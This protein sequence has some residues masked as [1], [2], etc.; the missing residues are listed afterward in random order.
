MRDGAILDDLRAT[1]PDSV[2][3]AIGE[4]LW[5]ATQGDDEQAREHLQT[6]LTADPT[7]RTALEQDP[8]LGPLLTGPR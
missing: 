7:V 1:K 8:D 2:G 3:V 6:A 4:A 5:E